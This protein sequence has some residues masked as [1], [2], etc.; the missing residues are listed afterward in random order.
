MAALGFIAASPAA[1][2]AQELK[3]VEHATTDAVTDTG[4]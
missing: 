4:G 3:M 2:A 1:F